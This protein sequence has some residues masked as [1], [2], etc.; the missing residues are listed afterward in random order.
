M[1]ASLWG[2]IVDPRLLRRGV[3]IMFADKAGMPKFLG[4]DSTEHGFMRNGYPASLARQR[5]Y[6]GCHWSAL[7]GQEYTMND[8]VKVNFAAIFELAFKNMMSDPGIRPSVSELMVSFLPPFTSCRRC[9]C[10][11]HRLSYAAYARSDAR[12][13]AGSAVP[14]TN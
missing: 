12:T 7:P 11:L 14:R 2:K 9:D 8:C 4:V 13:G 6:S 10:R 5:A 3:E 1:S